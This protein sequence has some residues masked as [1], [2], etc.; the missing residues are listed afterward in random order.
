MSLFEKIRRAPLKSKIIGGVIGLVLL[1][2][3]LMAA[4]LL[5]A[6]GQIL[7]PSFNGLNKDLAYCT[8]QAKDLWGDSCGNLRQS[9]RYA[10]EETTINVPGGNYELPGW[11]VTTK[12][13]D[14]GESRAAILLVHSGGSDRRE[15]TKHIPL[16]LSQ[17]MD[18]LTFDL[19]CHGEAPCPGQGL[20]YGYRESRDVIAA[21]ESLRERRTAV[22]VMGSSMGAT[23]VLAALPELKDAAGVIVENSMYSFERLIKDAPEAKSMPGLMSDAL[24]K[25]TMWRGGFDD[26]RT[27]ARSLQAVDS[28]PILFIHSK[29]DAIV[30]YGQTQK[31]ADLYKGPKTVWLAEQGKHSEIWN[32]NKAE[33]EQQILTFMNTLQ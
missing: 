2:A 16:F 27:P 1:A 10:F 13:N 15:D 19:S 7:A 31:L 5:M 25:L 24:I 32:T 9:K 20:T 21:Y 33:Y 8:D 12:A 29:T 26:S 14:M 22:Y 18:V 4:T 23:S 3:I 6:S 28:V 17:G 11:L 30:P